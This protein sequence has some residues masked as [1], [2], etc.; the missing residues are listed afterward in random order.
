MMGDVNPFEVLGLSPFDFYGG[1]AK[2]VSNVLKRPSEWKDISRKIRQLPR[3]KQSAILELSNCADNDREF[4]DF[5]G[6]EYWKGSPGGVA[7][8]IAIADYA[9]ENSSNL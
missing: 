7:I 9:L 3:E 2:N 1:I 8:H 4:F 5:A 6:L